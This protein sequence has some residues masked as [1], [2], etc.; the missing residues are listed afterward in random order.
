VK[1][2]ELKRSLVLE[3]AEE[4]VTGTGGIVRSWVPLG[5]HWA[6]MRAGAGRE[7]A[8]EEVLN[9]QVA[10]RI[11]LRGAPAGAPSRPRAGQ[12]FRD[13]SRVFAILAVAEADAAGRWLVCH[14]REEDPA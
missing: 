11:T 5:R 7:R 12:R 2:P 3:A 10:W 13:G 8:G 14:A 9:G 1:R 6:E 4:T